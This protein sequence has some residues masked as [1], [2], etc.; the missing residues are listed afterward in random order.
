LS[1][2][3][4]NVRQKG[5][6]VNKDDKTANERITTLIDKVNRLDQDVRHMNERL[7]RAGN[8]G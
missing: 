7:A 5:A 1:Y 3:A 6:F 8:H 2:T 4:N